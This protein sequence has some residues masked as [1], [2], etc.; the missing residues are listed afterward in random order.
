M[1]QSDNGEGSRKIVVKPNG[2][3]IVYGHVP[4]VRKTQVVSEHGEPLTWKKE[5]RLETEEP[6]LLCR[7]GQSGHKPFCDGT[8]CAVWFDGT[9]TADTR[10]TAERQVP[11]EG[12]THIV[13]K[14][15]A[16]LCIESGFCGNRRGNVKQMVKS[17]DDTEVR[18]LVMAMIERCPSGS[19]TY[20]IEP[21]EEDV[22]PDLP[23]QIA[24]TTDITSSGPVKG[25]L[26]VTGGIP[27]ERA[28]GQP[29]EARNRVTLCCCGL[30]K[31]KP[32]C[33]GA[34]RPKDEPEGTE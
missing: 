12:G 18:S 20:S 11:Y 28:D 32:L 31:I 5:E 4:L 15:D 14:S 29:F 34:H 26:W 6:Y 22:E 8:H 27:I 23:P 2:P 21:C 16:S 7:C 17:T 25:A 9:E 30:S 19:L 33:D 13:V 24:V 10:P 1:S 3:Y